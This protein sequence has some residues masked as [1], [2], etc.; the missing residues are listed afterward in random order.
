MLVSNE[1]SVFTNKIQNNS[2]SI[3]SN[4]QR[5]MTHSQIDKIIGDAYQK[6]SDTKK[7][8]VNMY[9]NNSSTIMTTTLGRNIF[10]TIVDLDVVTNQSIQ[11]FKSA[12]EQRKV[13]SAYA[14]SENKRFF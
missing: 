4:L 3:Y 8:H 14:T 10:A 12:N 13:E 6:I 11:D 5:D 2:T 1:L 7:N 9:L